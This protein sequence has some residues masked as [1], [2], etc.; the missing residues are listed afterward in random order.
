MALARII[1]LLSGHTSQKQAGK[2]LTARR[3]FAGGA[4]GLRLSK[5]VHAPVGE[6]ICAFNCQ[7]GWG[8]PRKGVPSSGTGDARAEPGEDV[9]FQRVSKQHLLV[10]NGCLYGSPRAILRPPKWRDLSQ[11]RRCL[12]SQIKEPVSPTGLSSQTQ[13]VPAGTSDAHRLFR[14]H[15]SLSC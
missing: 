7:P 8:L 13:Q 4:D 3:L 9:A 10:I 12:C 6:G 2:L 5:G 1:T 14:L 15:S 11:V